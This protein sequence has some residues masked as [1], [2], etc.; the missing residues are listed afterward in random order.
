MPEA[1]VRDLPRLARSLRLYPDYDRDYLEWLVDELSRPRRRGALVRQ[2]VRDESGRV[3]GWYV[4]Y[5]NPG[6]ISRVLQ[7]AGSD[8]DV[9]AV[10]DH[11][12]HHAES[13]GAAVLDGRLEARLL[14]PLARRRCWFRYT[15]ASAVHSRNPDVVAAL[16]S[17]QSLFTRMDTEYW[18][19]PPRVNRR[20]PDSRGGIEL[21]CGRRDRRDGEQMRVS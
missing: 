2:L 10:L 6:G 5:L 18:P 9:G 14:E 3:L 21:I 16:F 15:G 7:V 20:R 12:F 17:R 13:Q 11:L 8:N 19:I 1:I 4:Y